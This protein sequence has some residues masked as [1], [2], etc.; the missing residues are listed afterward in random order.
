MFFF[1]DEKGTKKS[2]LISNKLKFW[3]IPR[4][5]QNRPEK[6]LVVAF[7]KLHEP[8]FLNAIW[9]EAVET[10]ENILDVNFY[11]I[12]NFICLNDVFSFPF[13]RLF[14]FNVYI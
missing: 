10:G 9:N 1:L 14:C 8:K 3:S 4:T 13:T 7:K 6:G 5:L 2:R 12:L 11:Q